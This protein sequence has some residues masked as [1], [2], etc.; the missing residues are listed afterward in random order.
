[1]KK[2]E[3]DKFKA[4]LLQE[5]QTILQHLME[6]EGASI[7]ELSQ[8]GGDPADLASLEITQSSI[9]KLG[10]R[11]KKLIEKIDHALAK[12]ENGDFGV[13]ERCGE[14]ISPAR[15]DARPVAQYCID[16]KTEQEQNER[17]YSEQDEDDDDSWD[18]GGGGESFDDM[19]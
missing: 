3:Q 2:K 6:L 16:C 5:K 15:L 17:R 11:E 14:D 1:M 12:F 10:N 18:G 13:C 8:G 7:N 19:G 4:L 9:Q